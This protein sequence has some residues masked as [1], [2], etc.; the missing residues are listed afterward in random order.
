MNILVDESVDHQIVVRLREDRRETRA[1]A[2]S[3]LETELLMASQSFEP[4]EAHQSQ[5]RREHH[6]VLLGGTIENRLIVCSL[7]LAVAN[8]DSVV[9]TFA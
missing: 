7:H 1:G 5:C 2:T 3:F 8:V 9:V 6:T 4:R